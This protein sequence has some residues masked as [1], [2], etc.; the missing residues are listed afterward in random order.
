M[1]AV[2]GLAGRP[3]CPL[4]LAQCCPAR[5]HGSWQPLL[6]CGKHTCG[7]GKNAALAASGRG[8]QS[9]QPARP[10]VQAQERGVFQGQGG[11]GAG[12]GARGAG[13]GPWERRRK[14][15]PT[16]RKGPLGEM[17]R[18]RGGQKGLR[19]VRPPPAVPTDLGAI[20]VKLDLALS[21]L[22]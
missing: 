9:R 10:P 4:A 1:S 15:R 11:E 7:P 5:G 13:S 17:R 18:G 8:R 20:R 12:R 22:N 21:G 14:K 6:L 3:W 16:R 19:R 2:E